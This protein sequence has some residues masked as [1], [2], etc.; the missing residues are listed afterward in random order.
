MDE[1]G[2]DD[3]S[4]PVDIYLVYVYGE[5]E[6]RSREDI[7]LSALLSISTHRIFSGPD[8]KELS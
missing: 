1:K 3:V 2:G 7:S 5:R 6:D 8:K 4:G